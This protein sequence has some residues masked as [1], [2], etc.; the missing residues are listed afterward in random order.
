M[1]TGRCNHN[2]NCLQKPEINDFFVQYDLLGRLRCSICLETH[3]TIAKSAYVHI[4]MCSHIN[5]YFSRFGSTHGP[6]PE[7]NTAR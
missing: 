3:A 2:Q 1:Q 7:E 5:K 6:E 4:K